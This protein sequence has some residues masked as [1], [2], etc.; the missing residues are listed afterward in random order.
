MCQT[1][2]RKAAGMRHTLNE[3]NMRVQFGCQQG[4]KLHVGAAGAGSLRPR[5]RMRQ[6]HGH[7][8]AA[9]DHS[10]RSRRSRRSTHLLH[11]AGEAAK[12]LWGGAVARK[13]HLA[14]H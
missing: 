6:A 3:P 4:A 14:L 13:C 11:I 2:G 9:A 1:A 5:R 8:R 7:S 10:R 12:E